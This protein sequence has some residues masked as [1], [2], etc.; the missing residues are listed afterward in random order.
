MAVKTR[1]KF[2]TRDQVREFFKTRPV[3][4]GQAYKNLRRR[5]YSRKKILEE[6]EVGV[7]LDELLSP[8]MVPVW[9]KAIAA[10][11]GRIS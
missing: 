11:A 9:R 6:F 2:V 8:K 10:E 1:L 3:T 5:G 7:L 4:A